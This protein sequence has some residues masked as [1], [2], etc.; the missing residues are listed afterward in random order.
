VSY[1]TV[2]GGSWARQIPRGILEAGSDECLEDRVPGTLHLSYST[3]SGGLSEGQILTDLRSRVGPPEKLFARLRKFGESGSDE[4]SRILALGVSKCRILRGLA[5]P[6][7]P[8]EAG[9]CECLEDPGSGASTCRILRCLE[10]PGRARFQEVFWR[11]EVTN[12]SRSVSLGRSISRI[13][14]CLEASRRARF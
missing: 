4:V 9:S 10:A 3:V 1:S 7:G 2:S 8:V 11:L 14:R 13:L 12:V 6:G 5:A